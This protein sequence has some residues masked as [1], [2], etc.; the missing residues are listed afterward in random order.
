MLRLNHHLVSDCVDAMK[1]VTEY[2][3]I[4]STQPLIVLPQLNVMYLSHAQNTLYFVAT[5]SGNNIYRLLEDAR[6][7]QGGDF[8]LYQ[9]ERGHPVFEVKKANEDT[10][11]VCCTAHS[12]RSKEILR[13]IC[14]LQQWHRRSVFKKA[15]NQPFV[16]RKWRVFVQSAIRHV[17]P[18]EII[19]CI[20]S[21]YLTNNSDNLHKKVPLRRIE[22]KTFK[23]INN[24]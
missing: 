5:Y 19:E 10:P 9:N 16:F 8:R 18:E 7:P 4:H 14:L 2:F 3:N 20:L 23:E 13:D 17:L 11:S 21:F 6:L 15:L 24:I 12:F 22:T 1:E